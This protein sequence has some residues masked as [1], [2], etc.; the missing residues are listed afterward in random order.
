[1]SSQRWVRKLA[2]WSHGR[3]QFLASQW[4]TTAWAM[5]KTRS[6]NSSVPSNND[7]KTR[8]LPEPPDVD[9]VIKSGVDGSSEHASRLEIVGVRGLFEVSVVVGDDGDVFVP[10]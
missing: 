10:E 6:G 3:K 7:T 1:M 4:Q 5:G 9:G 2:V 8:C